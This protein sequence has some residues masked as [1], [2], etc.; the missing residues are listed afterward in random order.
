M[1]LELDASTKALLT[2]FMLGLYFALI[3]YMEPTPQE[4]LERCLQKEDHFRNM[5]LA[6][7]LEIPGARGNRQINIQGINLYT[8]KR[9]SVWGFD[10]DL[11]SNSSCQHA[12]ICRDCPDFHLEIGDTLIKK[13]GDPVFY[14]HKKNG[15][16]TSYFLCAED[17]NL[18]L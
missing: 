1:K 2:V 4:K 17:P 3:H 18:H 5:E 10:S 15:I 6:L 8:G 7:I 9:Q 13:K 14:L 11:Y 16:C 12:D